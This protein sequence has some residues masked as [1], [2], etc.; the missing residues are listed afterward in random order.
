MTETTEKPKTEPDDNPWYRLVTLY[1]Q[2]EGTDQELQAS[3]P[4]P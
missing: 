2:P 1:G 4:I 3:T